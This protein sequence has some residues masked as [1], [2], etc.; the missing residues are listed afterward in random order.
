ME[1]RSFSLGPLGTNCYIVYYDKKALIIDPGAEGERL[2]DWLSKEELEPLAILLTH[3]HFDHIGAVDHL[4]NFY[5][6]PVYMHEAEQEWLENPALNGSELFIGNGIS[7][8]RPDYLL[9]QGAFSIGEFE[10]EVVYTPGHSPGSISFL[11]TEENVIISGDVL[12]NQGIGRT[13]LHGG[14]YN[15]LQDTI[16]NKL[17]QLPNELIV[18]PGHGPQTTIGEE[19]L[20][21]PFV[22][23]K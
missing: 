16:K 23:E 9:D 22:R 14:D 3:A 7:T 12:F 8:T 4:R 2:I 18:Y 19:K 6:I 20:H 11:F 21:N 10:F 13:D 5:H 17:Y 1:L 15:L